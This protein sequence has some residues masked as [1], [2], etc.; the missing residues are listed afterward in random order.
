M[1]RQQQLKL[2]F[3][4]LVL[5]K[6]NYIMFLPIDNNGQLLVSGSSSRSDQIKSCGNCGRRLNSGCV[7]WAYAGVEDAITTVPRWLL[8]ETF[9]QRRHCAR[10]VGTIFIRMTVEEYP[11]NNIILYIN[12]G[13]TRT[14]IILFSR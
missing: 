3:I 13:T 5:V 14:N 11:K 10:M 4:Y 1:N 9:G 12:V 8:A 2:G 7:D 6:A